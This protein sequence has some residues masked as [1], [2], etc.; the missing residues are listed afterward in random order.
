MVADVDVLRLRLR[1]A[2]RGMLEG[3]LYVFVDSHRCVNSLVTR[4]RFAIQFY[5]T[6][7]PRRAVASVA[8]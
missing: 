1:D 2:C 5:P 7:R 8:I 4:P 3:A 6:L